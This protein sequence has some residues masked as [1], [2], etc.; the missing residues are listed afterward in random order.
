MDR[1]NW[2]DE[3]TWEEERREAM[4]KPLSTLDWCAL[5]TH[6]VK[7]TDKKDGP[8]V[9]Y[10]H[11]YFVELWTRLN[12]VI[13]HLN[14]V[15]E[16]VFKPKTTVS[17]W[18]IGT[19][20]MEEIAKHAIIKHEDLA[21]IIQWHKDTF[22][23]ATLIGQTEKFIEESKEYRETAPGSVERLSEIAD[24]FIV[25]CGIMNQSLLLGLDYM[26]K[27]TEL[28]RENCQCWNVIQAEIDY[29]MSKN[30]KRV[31]EYLGGGNYHHKKG[32]ED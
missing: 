19:S 25:A 22:P 32:V 16:E 13:R 10:D 14:S 27:V 24:L 2:L 6:F 9:V 7:P 23:K 17:K 26:K 31:W 5:S 11:K 21:S 1:P 4:R 15:K 12:T 8:V 29:K 28:I 20:V 18:E 3:K 30:R